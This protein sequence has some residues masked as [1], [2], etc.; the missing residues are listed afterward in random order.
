LLVQTFF[1][2]IVVEEHHLRRIGW[3]RPICSGP[4]HECAGT[5]HSFC[6]LHL[7]LSGTGVLRGITGLWSVGAHRFDQDAI[8]YFRQMVETLCAIS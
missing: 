2:A 4:A 6:P 1:V 5:Q 3:K 7:R 8:A